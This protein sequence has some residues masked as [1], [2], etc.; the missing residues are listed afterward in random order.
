MGDSS[1]NNVDGT[2]ST[3]LAKPTYALENDA[4]LAQFDLDNDVIFVEIPE[5]IGEIAIVSTAGLFVYPLD[6]SGGAYDLGPAG[7]LSD[8]G[9]GVLAAVAKEGGLTDN[10]IEIILAM[11][12]ESPGRKETIAMVIE[13]LGAGVY[14]SIQP[15][16]LYQDTAGTIP[17]TS[18]GDPVALMQTTAGESASFTQA[19]GSAQAIYQVDDF[20]RGYLEFSGAQFMEGDAN[21]RALFADGGFDAFLDFSRNENIGGKISYV[22]ASYR[23]DINKNMGIATGQDGIATDKSPRGYIRINGMTDDVSFNAI[24]GHTYGTSNAFRVI[25]DSADGTLTANINNSLSESTIYTPIASTGPAGR[26]HIG[27]NAFNSGGGA[28]LTGRLYGLSVF[29]VGALSETQANI[30]WDNMTANQPGYDVYLVAGQSNAKGRGDSTLSPDVSVGS[31]YNLV[32][33]LDGVTHVV[34]PVGFG[35]YQADT[36][37]AWPAFCENYIAERGRIPV[38]ANYAVGGTAQTAASDAGAGYWQKGQALYDDA[39]SGAMSTMSVMS[40]FGLP[41]VFRGVLWSQGERD[42]GEIDS[43]TGYTVSDY[44]SG[45][46]TM[47]SDFKNDLGPIEMWISQTGAKNNGDTTGYQEIRAAQLDFV[48]DNPEITL[49][50]AGAWRFGPRNMMSDNSHYTQ[51]AYDEMGAAMLQSLS[52]SSSRRQFEWDFRN[53]ENL[54][55]DAAKTT[56]VTAVGNPIGAVLDDGTEGIEGA[57]STAMARPI[58]GRM[59]ENGVTNL[60]NWSEDFSTAY[61]SKSG[62]VTASTTEIFEGS[63]S[64]GQY[65]QGATIGSSAGVHY[66]SAIVSR[67]SG[68]RNVEIT[69]PGLVG[70]GVTINLS[71]G[72][73]FGTTNFDTSSL[74]DL[75]SGRYKFEGTCTTTSSNPNQ[76]IY[77]LDGT[78]ARVNSGDG[79]SSI[80]VEDLTVAQSPTAVSYQ[81]TRQR[82]DITES[83]QNSVNYAYFDLADDVINVDI[84]ADIYGDIAMVSVYGMTVLS[85]FKL[86]GVHSIGPT[87]DGLTGIKGAPIAIIV[88]DGGI[89]DQ[90]KADILAKYPE[91]P[92]EI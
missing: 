81:H 91:C 87:A 67:G 63:I 52:L 70:G 44:I 20:G 19:S 36:G 27:S 30:V 15:Q 9:G 71:D 92:G 26:L 16:Y 35:D 85:W 21:A 29:P 47:W 50:F 11:Y 82:Y 3:E 75:G 38:I 24:S 48:I 89:T 5:M 1:P 62:G 12:P 74:T 55:T 45:F 32:G 2:Q 90:D 64:G 14:Y 17:V 37:S 28:Y 68:T 58:W 80:I 57:Q 59:P 7:V 40:G 60:V 54:Y 42:G 8:S 43:A 73:F 76:S 39:V 88:K 61:W 46:N 22:L 6:H 34:D 66:I 13:Q 49:G 25:V 4:Y 65:I 10:D 41:A 83:G 56:Q 86:A 78:G 84:P 33:T 53:S 51:P 69:A 31:A 77:I 18:P 23:G 79:T 72:T